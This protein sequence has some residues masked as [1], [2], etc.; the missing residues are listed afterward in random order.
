MGSISVII[1]MFAKRMQPH[2]IL[3]HTQSCS[4]RL[5]SLDLIVYWKCLCE[6]NVISLSI[7]VFCPED[8][9]P[10]EAIYQWRLLDRGAAYGDGYRKNWWMILLSYT[11][12]LREESSQ[13]NVI[14]QFKLLAALLSIVCTVIQQS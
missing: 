4:F 1:G 2:G 7:T 8:L 6:V 9:Y 3:P 10:P 14:L 5:V 13:S 11:P 12:T